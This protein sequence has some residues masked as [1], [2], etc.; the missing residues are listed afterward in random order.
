[1]FDKEQSGILNEMSVLYV[2]DEAAVRLSV[3]ESLMR[4]C[5]SV[6]LA[7]NGREGVYMYVA[8]RPDIVI[9]DIRMPKMNGL[10]M[11]REI[12]KHNPK[13]QII[14]TSA[15]SD[16]DMF[17]EAIDLGVSQYV[18]KPINI[19]K[20]LNTLNRCSEVVA[21]E[22]TFRESHDLF[23]KLAESSA[24]GVGLHRE[25]FL[26]VNPAM[27]TITGYKVAELLNMHLWDFMGQRWRQTIREQ[28]FWQ[29]KGVKMPHEYE[30]M[31]LITKVGKTK[32]VRLLTDTVEYKGVFC[33]L[34]DMVDIT[35]EKE[36]EMEILQLNKTLEERVIEETRK[37]R[38]QD[39]LLVQQSKMAAMGEMIGAIA[40]QW[41]QPLN[42]ISL[43]F[44]DLQDALA[45]NQ[46]D[47]DYMKNSVEDSMIQ[48]DFMSKAIEAF[49]NFLRPSKKKEAFNLVQSIRET[50][51]L[52][53]AMLKSLSI[54]VNSDFNDNGTLEVVGYQNEFKQV[55]FNIINNARDAIEENR[56][57]TG[58]RKSGRIDISV[59]RLGSKVEVEICDDGG[60]ISPEAMG[61]LFN[62]WFT[63]KDEK[64]GT[65]IGMYMSRTIIEKNMGGKLSASNKGD[66]AAFTI[67]LNISEDGSAG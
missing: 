21:A 31:E 19:D 50:L 16:K 20:L 26:Y 5:R 7:S 39:H 44:F 11:A 35:S 62:A 32:W 66:G 6:Y 51:L 4:C 56:A 46:L 37:L 67:Q 38:E 15:F 59:R 49:R 58:A 48:I 25:K 36:Y 10:D 54:K 52:F 40:H 23:K 64:K 63:T 61:K 41:R 8:Y 24:F 60:G 18:I 29:L 2:E 14:I 12:K 3:G 17:V 34:V 28:V 33:G 1:M 55:I 57:V 9:T 47:S 53:D 45:A 22:K 43:I 42:A 13:A 27:Q 65:G 30:E